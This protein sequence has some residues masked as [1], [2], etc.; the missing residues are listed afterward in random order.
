MAF[1]VHSTAYYIIGQTTS[2]GVMRV[3]M[4]MVGSSSA[5]RTAA[6]SYLLMGLFPNNPGTATGLANIGGGS[7]ILFL[8]L[9]SCYVINPNNLKPTIKVQE[10]KTE[11]FYFDHE[12]TDNFSKFWCHLG[13]FIFCIGLIIIPMMK[14]A[15]GSVSLIKKFEGLCK[16]INSK[17]IATEKPIHFN[18]E[19]DRN[20]TP[21][22]LITINT[23]QQKTNQNLDEG[24]EILTHSNKEIDICTNKKK[25]INSD[26]TNTKL[27]FAN[28]MPQK[29]A[30]DE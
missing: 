21:R 17:K 18:K 12:V 27:A 24:K 25:E 15:E 13:I 28:T 23:E 10:G 14:V 9:F 26:V 20:E 19:I 29:T 30:Q 2:F 16:G 4:V 5:I 3:C 7:V 22:K 8:G 1:I 6:G 11:V